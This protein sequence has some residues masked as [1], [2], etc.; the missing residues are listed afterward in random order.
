MGDIRFPGLGIHLKDVAESFSLFGLEV[1]LYGFVIA[2]GFMLAYFVVIKEAKRTGQDDDLYVDFML[3][4]I[5]PA[6]AGAR[7]YYVLF[8]WDSYFESGKGFW[9]TLLDI[10]NIRQGGLAIYGGIIAG[11]LVGVIFCK[12]KKVS[13]KLMADTAVMSVL[14]GQ[15]VGR[16]G[17][18]FNREAFGDYTDSLFRMCIPVSYFKGNGSLAPLVADGVITD[19]MINNVVEIDG[20]AWISVHPTFLYEALWNLALLIFIIVYRK[21]KKFDGELA[22][23]YVW[24]YGLGRVWIEGLRSDSL[25]IP[26][27]NMKVSQLIAAVCVLVASIIIVKKRIDYVK[28]SSSQENKK[29][30][31]V[32][33]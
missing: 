17:N 6:I 30:T 2:I 3:W 31:K 22:L 15:I 28:A 1:K 20:A 9:Q 10:I 32:D 8:S 26:G 18:F 5:I 21:H 16:F 25:M 12:K 23:L 33:A 11:V 29:K 19:S 4:M 7:L 13:I 14:I 27:V 24:G